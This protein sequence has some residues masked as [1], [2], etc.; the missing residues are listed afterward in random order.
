MSNLT[1]NINEMLN[2]IAHS[3]EQQKQTLAKLA[4]ANT[5]IQ[6]LNEKL[7]SDNL[8]MGAELEITREL[9]QKILP[10]PE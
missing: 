2:A 1:V 4:D 7:K 3:D 5:E 10:K 9:Q 8:R 6:T